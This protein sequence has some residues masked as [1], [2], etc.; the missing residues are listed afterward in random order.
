MSSV[1]TFFRHCPSCGRRFEVKLVGR[2]LVGTKRSDYL[3][4]RPGT[5]SMTYLAAQRPGMG[6]TRNAGQAA[7]DGYA[8]PVEQVRVTVE[9]KDFQHSYK[10]KHC[11]HQW[12]EKRSE[13]AQPSI[14]K[15]R[16]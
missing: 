11:G 15:R 5:S 3:S 16:S 4:T 8:A 2:N 1:T 7:Y 9:R 12:I 13:E 6:L 10:C 14:E